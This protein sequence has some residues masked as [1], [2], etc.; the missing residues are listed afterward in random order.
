MRNK[1]RRKPDIWR[2]SQKG[3][4]CLRPPIVRPFLWLKDTVRYSC[5]R[6]R[7]GFCDADLWEIDSWFVNIMP[8][9]LQRFKD[10]RVSSPDFENRLTIDSEY[11]QKIF[12]DWD[13][14]L[15]R[16]IVLLGEMK[17][18]D[19]RSMSIKQSESKDEFFELFSKY[20]YDLH[21]SHILPLVE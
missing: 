12:T 19:C 18:D 6:I 3:L 7:Y 2:P 11:E 20:F 21:P 13:D 10:T 8:A 16:M 14:I 17:V 4:Y 9:M 15:E 5:Q 1:N